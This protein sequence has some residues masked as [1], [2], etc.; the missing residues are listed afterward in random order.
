MPSTGTDRGPYTCLGCA[1]Y[2]H[3]RQVSIKNEAK[4]K[5]KSSKIDIE[6]IKGDESCNFECISYTKK[7]LKKT[8][9]S[10]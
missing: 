10:D 9:F 5:K 2:T 6:N 3:G 8:D 7:T 1:Q 4:K